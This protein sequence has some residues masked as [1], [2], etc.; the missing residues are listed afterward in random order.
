MTS[1]TGSVQTPALDVAL[2]GRLGVD[3]LRRLV[4]QPVGSH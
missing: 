1:T 2:S 4:G 3:A